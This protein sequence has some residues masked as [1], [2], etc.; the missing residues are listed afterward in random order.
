[1]K[2]SSVFFEMTKDE[3]ISC[4]GGWRLIYRD[5]KLIYVKD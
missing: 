2:D 5:G 4:Y 1:M 3:L